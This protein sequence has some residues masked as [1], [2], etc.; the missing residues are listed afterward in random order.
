MKLLPYGLSNPEGNFGGNQLLDG[1]MG[2]SP[3]Y[4]GLRND[5]RVSI[6]SNFHQGFP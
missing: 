1:S 4:P 2:L 3:L 5:L 6:T